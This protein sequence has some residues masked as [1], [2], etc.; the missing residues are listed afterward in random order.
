MEFKKY[1]ASSRK[2]GDLSRDKGL[3]YREGR[4]GRKIGAQAAGERYHARN[5]GFRLHKIGMKP[6]IR[7][8][9]CRERGFR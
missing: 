9:G 8:P 3:G 7:S 6:E 4:S 1:K 2:F 5:M